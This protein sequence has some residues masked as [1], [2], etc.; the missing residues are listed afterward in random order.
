MSPVAKIFIFTFSVYQLNKK[1][2]A[3]CKLSLIVKFVLTS[4]R[5]LPT[6]CDETVYALIKSGHPQ[7]FW[8][9]W[10]SPAVFALLW[11]SLCMQ[12]FPHT[13]LK[14]INYHTSCLCCFIMFSRYLPS[15]S[16]P[17]SSAS[18]H[19]QMHLAFNSKYYFIFKV[20]IMLQVRH[21]FTYNVPN[22][23]SIHNKQHELVRP[24]MRCRK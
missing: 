17:F 3:D 10:L 2:A 4:K 16:S 24:W 19:Y 21:M 23:T 5:L 13:N 11:P 22:V 14:H 8:F 1:G 9:N 12:C 18:V 15:F 7:A 20:I 6:I